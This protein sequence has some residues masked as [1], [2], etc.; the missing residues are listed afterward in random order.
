MFR[1][2]LTSANGFKTVQVSLSSLVIR[3]NIKIKHAIGQQPKNM[4]ITKVHI[5][6]M[7]KLILCKQLCFLNINT[8]NFEHHPEEIDLFLDEKNPWQE[9]IDK[10]EANTNQYIRIEPMNANQSFTV[11]ESF[12]NQLADTKVRKKLLAALYQP[13]PFRNF[14]NLIHQ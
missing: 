11:M 2:H 13:K 9:V 6:E 7:A 14:N 4:A 3:N 12:V 8:G 5:Q 10:I 1:L